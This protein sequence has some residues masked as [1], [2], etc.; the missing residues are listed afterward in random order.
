MG[1]G[2]WRWGILGAGAAAR[3]MAAALQAVNGRIEAIAR[4]GVV[5]IELNDALHAS[6]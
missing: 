1:N 6:N 2:H 5:G 3:G 4:A